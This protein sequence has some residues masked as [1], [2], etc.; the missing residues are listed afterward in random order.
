MIIDNCGYIGNY[1]KLCPFRL[2]TSDEII[3]ELDKNQID[4]IGLLSYESIHYDFESGNKELKKVYDQYPERIIPYFTVNPQYG[5][6]AIYEI[7]KYA[8]GLS[9]KCLKLH[10]QFLGYKLNSTFVYKTI[11]KAAKYKC[12][13]IIHTADVYAGG[14]SSPSMFGELSSSFSELTF[15]MCH[16]GVTNWPQA[17]EIA[18]NN[19]NVIL[20]TTGSV[21]NYGMIERSVKEIGSKRISWGSDYPMYPF[22]LSL[23]KIVHAEISE[24]DKKNILYHNMM[25]ILN[26]EKRINNDR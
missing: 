23:S 16:M 6:K 13:F 4:K 14:Q 3:K 19:S 21:I 1:V 22:E 24:E 11:E 7:D 20:G 5:N 9:W 2:R 8:G 10:P 25:R 17:I 18:K 15:I 26:L 12:I